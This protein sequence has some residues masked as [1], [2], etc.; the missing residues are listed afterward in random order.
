MNDL[1]KINNSKS[2]KDRYELVDIMVN[3]SLICVNLY[4][5]IKSDIHKGNEN[6]GRSIYYIT[7]SKH[8]FVK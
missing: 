8:N 1:D 3:V 7:L 2:L 5:I 6:M 4:V